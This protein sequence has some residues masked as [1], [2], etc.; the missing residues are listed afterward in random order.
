VHRAGARLRA[1][2]AVDRASPRG[3]GQRPRRRVLQPICG[4]PRLARGRGLGWLAL[5]AALEG[6]GGEAAALARPFRAGP[7]AVQAVG[8]RLLQRPEWSP[9]RL[10]QGDD[11][12]VVRHVGPAYSAL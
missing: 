10:E 4:V 7:T 6:L 12:V 2:G 3:D 8:V 9:V 11:I 5:V 1:H